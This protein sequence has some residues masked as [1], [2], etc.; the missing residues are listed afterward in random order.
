MDSRNDC[1]EFFN[2][3]TGQKFGEVRM[4]TAADV[5]RARHELSLIHI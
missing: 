2:P 5:A 1:I 3:A 4:A